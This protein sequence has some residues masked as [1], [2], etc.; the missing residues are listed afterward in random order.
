MIQVKV[1]GAVY[2]RQIVRRQTLEQLEEALNDMPE[3][4]DDTGCFFP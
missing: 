4:D 2:Q 3:R 1:D